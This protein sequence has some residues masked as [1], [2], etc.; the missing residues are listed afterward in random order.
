MRQD[1][2][3]FSRPL[4]MQKKNKMNKTLSDLRKKYNSQKL[5]ENKDD[6]KET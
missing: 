5:D 2:Y 6:L 3:T 4:T 1:L